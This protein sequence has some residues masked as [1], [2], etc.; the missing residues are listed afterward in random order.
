VGADED[1]QMSAHVEI[2]SVAKLPPFSFRWP[3]GIEQF[4]GG[5]S[6][7]ARVGG[8]V[9][10]LR[11]GLGAREVYGRLRVHTVTW[12]D[13][14]VQVEGAEADDYPTT[15]ALISRL[16]R[17]G[18]A[19]AR[20][21]E[22]V[23]DGYEGFEIVEHHREIEARY[24]PWCRAV[25]IREDDLASWAL[26]AWL[27]S[28]LPRKAAGSPRPSAASARTLSPT[29]PLEPSPSPDKKAVARAL[30]AHAESLA[31]QMKDAKLVPFTEDEE[32]NRLVHEDPFAF[33]LAVIS[34]MGIRAERAWALPYELRKR[35]GYLT[36]REL[37][38]NPDAVSAAFRE[39]PMLHRFVNM[40]AAWIVEAAQIVGDRYQ[41]DAG[42][43]WS[44]KP[45]AAQL[46]GRLE[47]LPGIGQ[48]KAA[49]AV[50]I[51]ERS[52]G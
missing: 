50:E 47:A 5:W 13:G 11:H 9:H 25:K 51:L 23:P 19:T 33:L 4:E 21:L 12:L 37:A 8:R 7:Q 38:A 17:P 22:E 29:V 3:V 41:G 28:Q 31:E 30:L 20:T 43:I 45:T 52:L 10:N 36:P 44:D 34:D 42:A 15:A 35:L 46:R 39:E 2:R 48:K 16:L 6:F 32:A 26:H 14:G 49:M 27:R 1:A 40:V 24:S 18:R